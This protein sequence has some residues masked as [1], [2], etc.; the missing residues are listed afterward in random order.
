MQIPE[1]SSLF[2][3]SMCG[4]SLVCTGVFAVMA[5]VVLRFTSG[6]LFEFAGGL[7]GN[8]DASSAD[9]AGDPGRI[10]ASRRD[11]RAKANSFDFD[12]AVRQDAQSAPNTYGENTSLRPDRRPRLNP[13]KRDLDL[14][15]PGRQSDDPDALHAPPPPNFS[16]RGEYLPNTNSNVGDRVGR[17]NTGRGQTGQRMDSYGSTLPGPTEDDGSSALRKRLR[18]DR[19]SRRD[20]ERFGGQ[21]D[22]DGDGDLDT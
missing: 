21:Y 19:N 11:L 10:A 12:A 2:V 14:R 1:I 9:P 17:H 15:P 8:D 4:L 3:L 7:F 16:T 18:S 22:F 13:D 5:F 20:D 6:E